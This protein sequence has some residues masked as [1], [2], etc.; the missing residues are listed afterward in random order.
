MN[1]ST[2]ELTPITDLLERF[3]D[4]IGCSLSSTATHAAQT[5]FWKLVDTFTEHG[6]RDQAEKLCR[7]LL[8]PAFEQ[9]GQFNRGKIQRRLIMMA[10]GSEGTARA[11]QL[12]NELPIETRSNPLTQ[13]LRYRIAIREH[14][15]V[16][17]LE[18][19]Q[20]ICDT[21]MARDATLLYACVLEAQASGDRRQAIAAL[22]EVTRKFNYGA[23]NGVHL[24][25]LLRCTARLLVSELSSNASNTADLITELCTLFCGAATQARTEHSRD[26][27]S[28]KVVQFTNTEVQWFLRNAYNLS[29]SHFGEWT[30]EQT[31][32][33]LECCQIFGDL[34]QKLDQTNDH[35]RTRR[36][37][38]V[39]GL[40]SQC[41]VQMA[42]QAQ[43]HELALQEYAEV[44]KQVDRLRQAQEQ[45]VKGGTHFEAIWSRLLCHDFEACIQL[46]LLDPLVK[47]VREASVAGVDILGK[48]AEMLLA[49]D[50][51]QSATVTTLEAIIEASPPSSIASAARWIRILYHL[52]TT[53]SFPDSEQKAGAMLHQASRLAERAPPN[54]QYPAEELEWLAT[55]TF[56]RAVDAYCSSDEEACRAR[57]EEALNI[58]NQLAGR[59]GG[60]LRDAMVKRAS[61]LLGVA[62]GEG[63]ETTTAEAQRR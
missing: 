56:N 35:E 3:T 36:M 1:P 53:S 15:Q 34:A 50:V 33:L 12:Y 30:S 29:V 25:A 7:L 21:S 46:R 2:F 23:P 57:V 28:S 49:C 43:D 17:A 38:V 61:G 27:Q 16:S 26:E 51:S 47:I 54:A 44:R 60:R 42:R 32:A 40:L 10:M 39:D 63:D 31:S 4:S 19:L 62:E 20:R 11:V 9:A 48:L 6:Q 37:I 8:H 24:P 52:C 55:T 14:D 59:D 18:A 45:A 22:R 5:I 41:L 58:A 13:Y